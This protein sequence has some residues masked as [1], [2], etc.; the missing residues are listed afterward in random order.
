MHARTNKTV[1]VAHVCGDMD[2]C[3]LLDCQCNHDSDRRDNGLY[4]EDNNDG[5]GTPE[6]EGFS[7]MSLSSKCLSIVGTPIAS[8]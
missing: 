6:S 4:N 7:L 1:L 2:V 5:E 3:A 8:T